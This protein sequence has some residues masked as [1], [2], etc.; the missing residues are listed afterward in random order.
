[1]QMNARKM[2]PLHSTNEHNSVVQLLLS[3]GANINLCMKDGTSPVHTACEHKCENIVQLLLRN[4]AIINFCKR[5]G[6]S[7]L[8]TAC[9]HGYFF[10]VELLLVN[11]ADINLCN[12]HKVLFI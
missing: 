1:M 10:I 4:G 5:N 9:Q 11:E 2:E 8:H 12:K 3:K 6:A 7:P